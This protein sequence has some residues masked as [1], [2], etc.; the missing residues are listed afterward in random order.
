MGIR[1]RLGLGLGKALLAASAMVLATEDGTGIVDVTVTVSVSLSLCKCIRK[2][3]RNAKR[4][5]ILC[6]HSHD[7][8]SHPGPI[9]LCQT[10]NSSRSSSAIK[11]DS[12]SGRNKSK[13][14]K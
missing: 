14:S 6:R 1:R 5:R 11:N 13:I 3:S 2:L 10:L 4:V 12:S 8:L 9:S 7:K